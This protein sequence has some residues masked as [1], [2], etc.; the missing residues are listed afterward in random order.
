MEEHMPWEAMGPWLKGAR[1]KT[2]VPVQQAVPNSFL[3]SPRA[4]RLCASQLHVG[5]LSGS[6]RKTFRSCPPGKLEEETVTNESSQEE[7]S[8]N[9]GARVITR[10]SP[11]AWVCVCVHARARV[12]SCMC[13]PTHRPAQGGCCSEQEKGP[14]PLVA[15]QRGKEG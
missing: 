14:W 15:W 7:Q 6:Q 4:E 10:Y 13:R 8:S 1:Q 11:G 3:R 9:R 2:A 12:C 5:D